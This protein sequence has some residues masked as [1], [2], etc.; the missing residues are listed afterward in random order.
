MKEG[1]YPENMYMGLTQPNWK[2]VR[3]V[4]KQISNNNENNNDNN[5]NRIF[6]ECDTLCCNTHLELPCLVAVFVL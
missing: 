6:I 1:A 5:N 4:W 2:K 3:E